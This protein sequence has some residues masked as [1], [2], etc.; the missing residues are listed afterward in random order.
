MGYKAIIVGA[1]GLIGG[2]L[3][4]ELLNHAEYDEVL[5]LVRKELPV[6]HKKLVQ[7][8]IDFNELPK[9]AASLTG[10]AVFS[11]LGTTKANTP[12]ASQY[13][14]IDHDYPLEI[15]R[16]AKANGVKQFHVVSAIGANANRPPFIKTKR[17]SWRKSLKTIGI[18][19][20]ISTSPPCYMAAVKRNVTLEKVLIGIFK[21]VDYL[22]IGGLR[23]YRS[24]DGATVAMPCTKIRW[25]ASRHTYLHIR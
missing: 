2:K 10:H 21:V 12:D 8:V 13:R 16:L 3:L 9:Y 25:Q 14:K 18:E 20:C 7:L 4:K 1:S 23:K 22:L 17:A 5:V 15:A 6:Q 11:C 24:I 19:S